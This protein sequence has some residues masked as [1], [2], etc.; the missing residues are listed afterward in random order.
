MWRFTISQF[1]I[2]AARIRTNVFLLQ[3]VLVEVTATT[4]PA[5]R[6]LAAV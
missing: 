6:R 1:I 2:A 3:A 5:T 4:P